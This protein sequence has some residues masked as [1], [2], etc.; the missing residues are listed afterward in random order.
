M[1]YNL[2]KGMITCKNCGCTVTPELKKGKYVYLRPNTKGDCDCKQINEQVAV[3]LVEDTLKSMTIPEDVLSMYLDRL[4]ERFDTQKQEITI[5]KKL[6][7]K[8]L[9][10]IKDSL[11]ELLDFC[12]RKLITKEQYLEKKAELEQ[13]ASILKEQISKFD[14][15]S[16]Q[17][18]L[19]MKHLL[20]VGSRVFELYSSS[21]IERKRS[22]LK[23][24]F[25][26]FWLDGQ[27]LSYDIKKPFDTFVKGAICLFNWTLTYGLTLQI[28]QIAA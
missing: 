18:E 28:R 9:A 21:G 19:S 10:C 17:V 25:P 12:I 22:I 14:Q 1:S 16:E 23:L 15:N 13:H 5:Q 8:E 20:K 2:F 6:K 4:K 24:V 7:Q 3:K 11:D 27:K 26:N